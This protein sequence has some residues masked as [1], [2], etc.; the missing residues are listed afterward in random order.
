MFYNYIVIWLY[1]FVAIIK[2]T[3]LF[4]SKCKSY[5]KHWHMSIQIHSS[6][7][8]NSNVPVN[9]WSTKLNEWHNTL[10]CLT[11]ILDERMVLPKTDMKSSLCIRTRPCTFRFY[12]HKKGVRTCKYGLHCF[13]S[14]VTLVSSPTHDLYL[15]ILLLILNF[16]HQEKNI[17]FL[18]KKNNLSQTFKCVY[19][20]LGLVGFMIS[21]IF[22]LFLVL[23]N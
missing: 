13:R 7:N 1:N 21:I 20:E 5:T 4:T 22:F 9:S 18:P 19:H 14:W 17:I 3:E 15:S 16:T 23:I 10:L 2:V 11:E 12:C 8:V 6:F